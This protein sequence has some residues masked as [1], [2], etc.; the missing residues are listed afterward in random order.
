MNV[1]ARLEMSAPPGGICVSRSVRDHIR[2][3]L[4]S[5]LDDLGRLTQ[6]AQ[7]L[8]GGSIVRDCYS[9]DYRKNSRELHVLSRGAFRRGQRLIFHL[10][11]SVLGGRDDIFPDGCA[12]LGEKRVSRRSRMA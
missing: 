3:R 10:F 12:P 2:D 5:A 1:A 4:P 8:R 6:K 7:A 9:P 11:G